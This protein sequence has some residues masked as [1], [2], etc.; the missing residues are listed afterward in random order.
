MINDVFN[1]GLNKQISG[2]SLPQAIVISFN[3]QTQS[4]N[5]VIESREFQKVKS[6]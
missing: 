1:K 5:Y 6:P 2:F 4:K 3:Y